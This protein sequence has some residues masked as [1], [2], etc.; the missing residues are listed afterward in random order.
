MFFDRRGRRF[1]G[2]RTYVSSTATRRRAFGETVIVLGELLFVTP[3]LLDD[4]WLSTLVARAFEP[5]LVALSRSRAVSKCSGGV[6][7]FCWLAKR[8]IGADFFVVSTESDV[9]VAI[10]GG[11]GGVSSVIDVVCVACCSCES[12]DD[13]GGGGVNI[14]G[15]KLDAAA[16]AA[17]AADLPFSSSSVVRCSL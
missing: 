16:A 6:T 5:R 2:S 14:G 8:R 9:A 3:I 4:V 1:D 15:G 7:C 12:I 11:F 17:A 13:G 10:D